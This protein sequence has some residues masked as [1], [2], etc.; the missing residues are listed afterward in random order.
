[1]NQQGLFV[2]AGG[3]SGI[4]L[5]VAETAAQRGYDLVLI[6]R[7]EPALRGARDRVMGFGVECSTVA[8]DITDEERVNELVQ[9]LSARSVP[10][11]AWVHCAAVMTYGNVLDTPVEAFRRVLDVNVT[12]VF[13][14]AKAIMPLFHDQR[15]GHFVVMSSTLGHVVTPGIA[16]Y[17]TSKW[18]LRG[19]LGVLRVEQRRTSGIHIVEVSP[20]STDTPIFDRAERYNYPAVCPPPPVDQATQVAKEVMDA[21]HS[22]SPWFRTRFVGRFSRLTSVVRNV[23][24]APVDDLIALAWRIASRPSDSEGAPP[25]THQSARVSGGWAGRWLPRSLLRGA[26]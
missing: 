23:S 19:L 24:P 8:C 4:G 7:G 18:A 17:V 15:S 2:V 3:S 21:V 1:M 11:V 25:S 14:A 10:V 22:P 6:G 12:G 16:P 20:W 5:A 13:V 9:E 26:E